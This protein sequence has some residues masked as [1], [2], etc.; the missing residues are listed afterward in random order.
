MQS[1]CYICTDLTDETSPCKC[2]ATVHHKCLQTFVNQT[3][4]TICTI[5]KNEL[6]GM[7][8]EDTY[9][10]NYE[11]KP[12]FNLLVFSIWLLCGFLGKIYIAIIINPH[13]MNDPFF[14]NPV[15]VDFIIIASGIFI[16]LKYLLRALQYIRCCICCQYDLYEDLYDS[17]DDDEPDIGV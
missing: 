16:F 10:Y 14:W 11:V 5:C 8:V 12:V 4:K 7:I 13:L 3:D 1:E 9:E 6:E 15:D 2:A 17:D